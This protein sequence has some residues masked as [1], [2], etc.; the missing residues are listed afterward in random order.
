LNVPVLGVVMVVVWMAIDNYAADYFTVL[1]KKY[2]IEPTESHQMLIDSVH[3]YLIQASVVAVGLAAIFSYW[4]T[5]KVLRPLSEMAE[6]T[7]KIA[8][9]DYSGRVNVTSRDEIGELGL[10]FNQIKWLI[11]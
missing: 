4:L 9:G 1:M 8:A 10:V 2:H 3:Y 5:K 6:V 11:T 7:K